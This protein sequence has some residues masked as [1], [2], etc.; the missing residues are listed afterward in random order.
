MHEQSLA[1]NLLR[2]VD[3]I[4][5]EHDSHRVVEV[6]VEI[7]PLSG[8]EPMLLTSAFER[9]CTD[10]ETRT[11]SLVINE[12]D[13]TV[14]CRLCHRQFVVRDYVFRCPECGGNVNVIRGADVQLVN[15]SLQFDDTAEETIA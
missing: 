12:V 7:G 9:L 8:V 13:L 2:Q 14:E 15:V 5:R 6:R 1:K 4:R 3:Q 10:E 11:A